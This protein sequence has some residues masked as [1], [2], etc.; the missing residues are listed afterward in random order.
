MITEFFCDILFGLYNFIFD[1]L[2][3]MDWEL[4]ADSLEAFLSYLDMAAY[5]VPIAVIGQIL[6]II[7]YIELFKIGVS[8]VRMVWSILPFT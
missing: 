3:V 7:L 6:F 8:L 5:F 4:P 1:K 2:P